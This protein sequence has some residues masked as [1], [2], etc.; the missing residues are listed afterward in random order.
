MASASASASASD[1]SIGLDDEDANAVWQLNVMCWNVFLRARNLFQDGQ[2]LRASYIGRLFR[3]QAEFASADVVVLCEVFD[4]ECAVL[5]CRAMTL[6]GYTHQT[7]VLGQEEHRSH[8]ILQTMLRQ[9]RLLVMNGGVVVYS[10]HPILSAHYAFFQGSDIDA[11]DACAMKGFV[12]VRVRPAASRVVVNVV[13]THLQATRTHEGDRMRQKQM[14]RIHQFLRQQLIPC[15]EPII[16]AGDLNQDSESEGQTAA[17]FATLL[18]SVQLARVPHQIPHPYGSVATVD[19][20]E[21]NLVGRDTDVN[22]PA[23]CLDHCALMTTH[24]RPLMPASA[25]I[26]LKPTTSEPM[27]FGLPGVFYRSDM[28]G[29]T[30]HHLSDHFPLLAHLVF[31]AHTHDCVTLP[32]DSFFGG[33]GGAAR[34]V[35]MVSP[36]PPPPWSPPSPAIAAPIE[37][38]KEQN[39]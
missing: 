10:R 33:G 11:L 20:T 35:H 34:L 38:N 21:N 28:V 30:T 36:S 1:S 3:E 14:H 13:G 5:L 12:Y 26:T 29:I 25:C 23:S 37:K 32:E 2:L 8:H 17:T 27:T 7:R 4:H 15:N 39:T 6:A 31:P 16:V 22:I 18:A 24:L 19:S 9:Q